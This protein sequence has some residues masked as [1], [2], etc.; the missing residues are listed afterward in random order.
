MMRKLLS[1]LRNRGKEKIPLT[2]N[3]SEKIKKEEKND[4]NI[5]K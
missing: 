5:K 3:T 4:K 1:A 2:R